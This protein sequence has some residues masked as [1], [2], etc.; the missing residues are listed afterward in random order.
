MPDFSLLLAKI[1]EVQQEC[2]PLVCHDRRSRHSPWDASNL[3]VGGSH[4]LQGRSSLSPGLTDVGT[5]RPSHLC[6]GHVG[7]QI[8]FEQIPGNPGAKICPPNDL[9]LFL[10]PFQIHLSRKNSVWRTKRPQF[11]F[12]LFLR[13]SVWS[14]H[15]QILSLWKNWSN[16]FCGSLIKLWFQFCPQGCYDGETTDI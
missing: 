11:P 12:L 15:C 5:R 3:L 2:S 14:L 8:S 1:I 16:L 7:G 6:K 10:F 4:S 9:W 13:L